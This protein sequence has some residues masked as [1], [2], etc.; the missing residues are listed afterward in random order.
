MTP[1]KIVPG[2]MQRLLRKRISRKVFV[3]TI[4]TGSTKL[5]FFVHKR[6][7]ENVNNFSLLFATDPHQTDAISF[8]GCS[9]ELPLIFVFG[10][11]SDRSCLWPRKNWMNSRLLGDLSRFWRKSNG[12]KAKLSPTHVLGWYDGLLAQKI[13]FRRLGR[14]RTIYF[15]NRSRMN[16]RSRRGTSSPF[17]MWCNAPLVIIFV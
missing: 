6:A 12:A 13:C 9:F 7:W 1:L 15:K 14:N 5:G 2:R 17:V 16:V 4:V 3:G 11:T 8:Y 10:P